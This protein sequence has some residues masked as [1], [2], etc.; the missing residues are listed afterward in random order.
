MH[1]SPEDFIVTSGAMEAVQLSL[2]A[3]PGRRRDRH[4]VSAYF[5]SLQLIEALG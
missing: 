3:V 4:R 5:G 2:L 1:L